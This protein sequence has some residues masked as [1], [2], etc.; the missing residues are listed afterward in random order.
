VI[1]RYPLPGLQDLL[2]HLSIGPL[3]P[4]E[5]RR[6]FLRLEALRTLGNDDAALVHRL[7]GGHPRGLRI[8]DNHRVS[9][10]LSRL[11]SFGPRAGPWPRRI[12]R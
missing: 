10:S 11:V 7:V 6:L 2:H 1:C 12:G 5:T 8:G 3:S 9:N 4:S